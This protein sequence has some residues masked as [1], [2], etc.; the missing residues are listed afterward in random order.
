MHIMLKK[1]IKILINYL[2]IKL[3][4][5]LEYKFKMKKFL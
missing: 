2:K 3:F 1:C 4:R 5:N